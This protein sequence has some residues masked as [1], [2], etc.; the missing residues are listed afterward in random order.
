M[1]ISHKYKFIFIKTVKTAGTSIEV[2]LSQFCGENDIVT[3]IWPHVEPHRARNYQGICNPFPEIINNKGQGIKGTVKRLLKREKFYNHIPAVVARQR[4]STKIWNSYYKFCVERNPWDKTLSHY[5]MMND[6]AGGSISFDDYIK[7]GRFCINLP[8]YTDSKGN[9]LVDK[10]VKY[11][12]LMDELGVV[13]QELGIPF[14]GS[15]GVRAKTEY[16]KDRRPYQNVFSNQQ[17][18][19]I[20]N[21]FTKEIEMHGYAF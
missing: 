8:K 3:P 2:F 14:D 19:V 5:H 12:S 7:E 17:R 21:A 10:V 16:R 9:I 4:M 1:I 15:L 6:W 11:E 20:E 13:F 18:D